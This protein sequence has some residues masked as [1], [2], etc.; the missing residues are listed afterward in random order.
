MRQI[1]VILLTII[2]YFAFIG[3]SKAQDLLIPAPSLPASEYYYVRLAQTLIGSDI[4]AEHP[5]FG[6]LTEDFETTEWYMGFDTSNN[7]LRVVRSK[8]KI[9][10]SIK[11]RKHKAHKYKTKKY[12]IELTTYQKNALDSLFRYAVATTFYDLYNREAYKHSGSPYFFMSGGQA[13]F[14]FSPEYGNSKKLAELVEKLGLIVIRNNRQELEDI[15]PEV[16]RLTESFRTIYNKIREM[17][18][19]DCRNFETDSN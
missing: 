9:Y 19:G 16:E 2:S 5:T 10:I 12:D 1:A 6:V 3:K 7:T 13:A 15:M 4:F 14:C 18:I 17:Q 8:K 11:L